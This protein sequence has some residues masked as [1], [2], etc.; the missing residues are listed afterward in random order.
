[1]KIAFLSKLKANYI[2]KC[3]LRLN[4]EIVSSLSPPTNMKFKVPYGPDY[5]TYRDRQMVGL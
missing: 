5:P 2:P 3:L 4:P 1:M